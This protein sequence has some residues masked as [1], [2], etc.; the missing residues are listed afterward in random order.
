MR[1]KERG[2]QR[3]GKGDGIRVPY[4][5]ERAKTRR[6]RAGAREKE[7]RVAGGREVR[8]DVP[9]KS[10]GICRGRKEEEEGEKRWMV[11]RGRA[12]GMPREQRERD[13][14]R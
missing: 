13:R 7:R 3:E 9:A 6:G 10:D 11:K 14:K 12:S 1:E 4:I 8:G 5:R 2:R